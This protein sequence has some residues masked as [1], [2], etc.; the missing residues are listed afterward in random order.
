MDGQRKGSAGSDNQ[1]EIV[2]IPEIMVNAAAALIGAGSALAMTRDGDD[3]G[4]CIFLGSGAI[5]VAAIVSWNLT[6]K[7]LAAPS[8]DMIHGVR[9]GRKAVVGRSAE[10]GGKHAYRVRTAR[11]TRHSIASA[12]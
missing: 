11:Q 10:K 12:K 8:H 7:S 4:A 6:Q 9:D 5:V 2:A 1:Q 3:H